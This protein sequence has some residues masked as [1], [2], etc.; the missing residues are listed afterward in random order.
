MVERKIMQPVTEPMEWVS[1]MVVTKKK[2]K[3]KL[4]ICIDPKDM[5]KA[6]L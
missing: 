3:D 4:H 5:N 6:I 2:E 1:T